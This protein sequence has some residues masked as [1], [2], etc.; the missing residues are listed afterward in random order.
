MYMLFKV[1]P[2]IH[3]AQWE[4]FIEEHLAQPGSQIDA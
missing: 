4:G 1:N 3:S 2:V